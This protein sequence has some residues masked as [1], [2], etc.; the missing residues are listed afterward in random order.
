LVGYSQ[1]N[2]DSLVFTIGYPT[3]FAIDED[4][5]VIFNTFTFAYAFNLNSH[6]FVDEVL[7]LLFKV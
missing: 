1:F 3:I 5:K 6:W 7:L 4:V 2:Y